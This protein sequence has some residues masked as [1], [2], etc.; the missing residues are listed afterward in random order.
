MGLTFNSSLQLQSTYDAWKRLLEMAGSQVNIAS[1]YWTL[2]G[3][4]V[5]PD[6]TAAQ[7]RDWLRRRGRVQSSRTGIELGSWD[8][9]LEM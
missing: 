5:Q 1:Y 6:P 9:W 2:L 3:V 8:V 7:V 4:D